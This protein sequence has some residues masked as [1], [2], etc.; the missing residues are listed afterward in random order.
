M[1]KDRPVI[2]VVEDE[3][4]VR[5]LV[6]NYLADQD[7]Q[8]LE[9]DSGDAAIEMLQSGGPVDVLLTDIVMPGSRDGFALA[10]EARRLWPAVKVLHITGQRQVLA[11]RGAEV[12][13]EEILAKPFGQTELLKRISLL[14]GRWAVDRNPILRRAYDYWL[15][16]GQGRAPDRRDL[17]ATEIKDILPYLSIV[18][19]VGTGAKTHHRY[20]LVGTRVAGALGYDPTNHIVE[21]FADNGHAEF[22]RQLI[23]DVARTA[24]PLYAASSFRSKDYGVSTERILLPFRRGG[25]AIRQVVVAQTFDWLHRRKTIHD[26]TA[27]KAE[28]FD[29]VE[30]PPDEP[31]DDA[32]PPPPPRPPE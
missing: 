7:Y 18:E 12:T 25:K 10:N 3:F 4:L 8:V 24:Q 26:L 17:D 20:R 2:L 14:L 27:E 13:K 6:R 23:T 29:T 5:E 21:E 31:A 1:A 16:K 15:E 30:R 32:A 22:L 11:E 9:A 28:R 19:I